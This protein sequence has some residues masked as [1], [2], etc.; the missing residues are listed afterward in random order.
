MHAIV[1]T[2]HLFYHYS[3]ELAL[4]YFVLSYIIYIIIYNNNSNNTYTV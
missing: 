3:I 1:S 2:A 4:T